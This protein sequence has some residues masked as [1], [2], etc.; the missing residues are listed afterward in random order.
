M[1]NRGMVINGLRQSIC[2][3]ASH[4]RPWVSDARSIWTS[5]ARFHGNAWSWYES[6]ARATFLLVRSVFCI[7]ELGDIHGW[8]LDGLDVSL[9]IFHLW[10]AGGGGGTV[11][12]HV[13]LTNVTRVRFRLRAVIRLKLPWSHVRRVLSSLTLP[14]IAGFLRVVRFPSVVTLD[15]W[16]VA[17]T[18]P[19]GRT[20][21][22]T[23]RIIQYKRR[24]FTLPL[25]WWTSS[26][27]PFMFI[28]AWVTSFRV[29]RKLCF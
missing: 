28:Q 3:S 5:S 29:V 27:H 21:R 9:C 14:S 20:A 4:A 13:S 10:D 7:W 23:D 26:D 8:S 6:V 11:V 25:V 19:L 1:C 15:P 2:L 24:H 16:E 17:L 18:G 22:V 12:V